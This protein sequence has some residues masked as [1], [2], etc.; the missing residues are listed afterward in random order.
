MKKVLAIV[1]AALLIVAAL[2]GCAAKSETA[3]T[4]A[5]TDTATAGPTDGKL[6]VLLV[7]SPQSLL[8]LTECI[9]AVQSQQYNNCEMI[10][11]R[12]GSKIEITAD[13]EMPWTLDGEREDGHEHITVVN[14]HLAYRLVQKPR[15]SA[16]A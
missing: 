7:R 12:S 10:T 1:L 2:A 9:A 15:E 4:T 8:E 14:K 13:P 6:E 16:D 3:D 11:F 5:T